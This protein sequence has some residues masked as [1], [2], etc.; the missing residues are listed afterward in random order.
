MSYW[1]LPSGRPYPADRPLTRY[2]VYADVVDQ[3]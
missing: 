1:K 3:P 2:T